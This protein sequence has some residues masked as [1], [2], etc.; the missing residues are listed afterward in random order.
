VQVIYGFARPKRGYLCEK[1]LVFDKKA[2][3]LLCEKLGVVYSQDNGKTTEHKA[4]NQK[5]APSNP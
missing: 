1:T 5:Q 4:L 3:V 2:G